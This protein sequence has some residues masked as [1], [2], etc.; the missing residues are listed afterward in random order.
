M[1][2]VYL[3]PHF[4]P[5]YFNF[6]LALKRLGVN[7]LGLGDTPYDALR[8]ELRA[9]FNEYFKV[10]DM[11]N[12]DQL[13]KAMGYL[14]YK[15]GK[16]DGIDSN[17]EYWLET[18]ARLRSDFNIEGI[19]TDKLNMIK[20]K[21][22]MKR[23]YQEAGVPVARGK[24]VRTQEDALEL[25]EQTG[26]PLVAKPDSGVGAANTYKINSRDELN[27]FF[28]TKPNVNYILEEFIDGQIVSFD[29]LTDKEGNL[30]FFTGHVYERGVMEV[31]NKDLH[32]Y[33][34]SLIDIPKDIET[35]GRKILKAFNVKGRFFHFE[36]F[37]RFDTGKLVALEVNMRPPGGFTT[38][39]FNYACD[40]DIYLEWANMLVNNKLTG[41]YT[42]NYH[43]MYVS[44]KHNKSYVLSHD[45][46]LSN[47]AG[48]IVHH[49]HID[50]ALATALGNYGYL[51]RSKNLQQLFDAQKVIHQMKG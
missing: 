44:R 36:F 7:V 32:I 28:D 41:D 40:F 10:E 21:S 3:S 20:N 37:R 35:A 1:N 4:P 48:L 42:R 29:G 9:A 12:Y 49:D 8:P 50:N 18:E 46:V 25:V 2:Y 24:I 30:L 22:D 5:N 27:N 45:D 39:M 16:I 14:T 19:R 43:V 31:V 38:D 6:S 26:F 51:I 33:Y 34:Y 13:V 11:H 47:F 17:N 15:H 23:V